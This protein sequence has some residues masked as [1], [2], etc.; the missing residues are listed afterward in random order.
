M[1]KFQA[2]FVLLLDVCQLGYGQQ[3]IMI[4]GVV[5]DTNGIALQKANVAL[6]TYI[7][8]LRQITRKDGSFLFYVQQATDFELH[9]TMNS[10]TTFEK[11]FS[12]DQ[13]QHLLNLPPIVLTAEYKQLAPVEV[14]GVKPI[15][16]KEDTLTYNAAAYV[17]R[18]GAELE[19][20]LRKLPGISWDMDGNLLVE[21]IK[22]NRIMVNGQNVTVGDLK[23][24][25]Q[26]LPADVIDNVQVID[27]YGDKA[28]LTGVKSGL[29]EKVLNIN[30]KPDDRH[31]DISRAE[32][33]VGDKG[34]Y[35]GTFFSEFFNNDQQ[36]SING[37]LA[38]VSPAGDV[39]EKMLQL[40]YA[41]KWN[42]NW[43]G[44]VGFGIWGD[45]H[46]SSTSMTQKS[47]LTG[48]EGD[49]QESTQT[50][51]NNQNEILNGLLKYAPDRNLQ[52][53]LSGFI[54][55][56]HNREFLNNN[57]TISQE[58]SSFTKLDN[59]V[60]TSLNQSNSQAI[61]TNFYFEKI[62]PNNG[63]KISIEASYRYKPKQQLETD[64]NQAQVEADSLN[65]PSSQDYIMHTGTIEKELSTKLAYYFPLGHKS[66]LELAY[67]WNY[68]GTQNDR[69]TQTPDSTGK[70]LLTIDSLSNK[71]S[72]ATTFNRFHV[73]YL[74][75][76]DKLSL[77]LGLDAQP[78]NQQGQTFDKE[79]AQSY[80][81]FALLPDIQ[82]VYSLS[83]TRKINFQFQG[84]STSPTPQEVQPLI[85]L[86]NPQYPV[87]GNPSLKP[88]YTDAVMV[89]Y[90]Q[91][92]LKPGR[93]FRFA[94]SLTYTAAK[95]IIVSNL[96]YPHDTSNIVQET[97]YTNANGSRSLLTNYQMDLP[98][99]LQ[100]H[101]QISAN[102]TIAQKQD[103]LMTD[104]IP[105]KEKSLIII[106]GLQFNF[107]ISDIIEAT[108]AGNYTH[109]L[110]QYSSGE[111]GTYSCPVIT[112]SFHWRQ[113]FWQ[114]WV[115]EYTL[116]QIFTGVPGKSLQPNPA[117]INLSI[118]RD[119]L[120]RNQGALSFSVNDLLNTATGFSQNIGPTGITQYRTNLIGRYFL[121]SMILKLERFRKY[122]P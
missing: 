81:Y 8:T 15:T 112:W 114:K 45:N 74:G 26:N 109:T 87:Q 62:N 50:H 69:L 101:I 34:R 57:Y 12:M 73:G 80:R 103:A 90:A 97:T 27:D 48:T 39:N 75:H 64:I 30:L 25:L 66:L 107:L 43:S 89:G 31:G 105:Y 68:S 32:A 96:I 79:P 70:D 99:L 100:R 41:S 3:E 5:R 29:P 91:S 19:R 94:A 116:N 61:G 98:A 40:G 93:Y 16:R 28:R 2:F 46:V 37:K 10:Y 6:I 20:L 33:G 71:Y 110:S 24:T 9:V 76:A 121:I 56:Y 119:L 83:E 60:T 14:L 44:T 117:I 51:G 86:T 17:L 82:L 52:V 35:N 122:N 115:M 1:I 72:F 102:G 59:G 106:Q 111:E 95:D 84:A 78:A 55:W 4:S 54:A 53:R 36:W 120:P 67:G 77:T 22:I 88:T 21:G 58:D 113:Q 92:S 63:Q 38:N 18:P 49:Q 13:H 23:A 65:S 85:D 47:Y 104:N 118:R 42:S 108:L 11:G 7:D